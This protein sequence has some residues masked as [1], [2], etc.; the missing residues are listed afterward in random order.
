MVRKILD[1]HS[2]RLETNQNFG[3]ETFEN[4]DHVGI[5][6]AGPLESSAARVVYIY[7]RMYIQTFPDPIS[8]A[9]FLLRFP[10]ARA[11]KAK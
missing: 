3:T 6:F 4:L 7:I 10:I 8:L 5:A 9:P 1:I 11:S 2:R